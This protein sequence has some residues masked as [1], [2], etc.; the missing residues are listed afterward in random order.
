MKTAVNNARFNRLLLSCLLWFLI[1]IGCRQPLSEQE[2][3][4]IVKT[5][6]EGI[7][8]SGEYILFWDGTD[9]ND[10][11]VPV[12]TYYA[13]LY[14]R[15]FT[16]QIEMTAKEGGTGVSNRDELINEGLQPLTKLEQ[17]RPNPFNIQD[18]TNIPFTIDD[19]TANT[20]VQLTIRNRN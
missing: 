16:Y 3:D 19:Q 2:K 1:I 10:Q 18:G 7:L 17:N 20:T 5:L 6:V 15:D 8:P 4:A 12:G 14:S 13:R 11:F 9:E